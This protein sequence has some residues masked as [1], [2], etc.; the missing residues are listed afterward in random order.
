MSDQ[1]ICGVNRGAY[2]QPFSGVGIEFD[3]LGIKPDRSGV[4][5][6]ETGYVGNNCRWN[7]PGVFSPFWRLNY[8]SSRGH[9]V[10]FGERMV[11]IVPGLILLIPPHCLIHC[12]GEN[13]VPSFWMT[14]S[15]TRR[16]H[17]DILPPA[18]LR[19]RDTELCLIRDLRDRILSKPDRGADDAIYRNSIALLQVTLSRPELRWQPPIPENLGRAVDRIDS[20]LDTKFSVREM[21]KVAGMSPAGFNRGFRRHFGTSPARFVTERRIREAA[22][23]LLQSDLT[24]EAI[25]ETTGFPNRAY[26]SRVFLQVAGEAPAGFRRRHRQPSI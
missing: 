26:F 15:F 1:I 10:L 6:H 17:P 14:F 5:L 20:G 12:L 9:C 25:A 19:A 11:E 22:R 18:L 16:L 8:N 23:L 7:F 24:I 3:P 4:T 21:A 2:D 13:P